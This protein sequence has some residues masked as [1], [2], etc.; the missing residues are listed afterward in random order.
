MRSRFV[1]ALATCSL[2]VLLVA[3]GNKGGTPA[4][5]AA[6]TKAPAAAPTKAPAASQP[7]QAVAAPTAA[8]TIAAQSPSANSDG[9]LAAGF[10]LAVP[11]PDADHADALGLAPSI[12]LNATEDPMVAYL[13]KNL[14]GDGYTLY[15]AQWD[16]SS[17]SWTKPVSIDTVNDTFHFSPQLKLA[18]DASNNLLGV[19][20]QQSDGIDRLALSTDNGATWKTEE[21]TPTNGGHSNNPSLAMAN[22][23]IYVAFTVDSPLTVFSRAGTSGAFTESAAPALPGTTDARDVA[24]GLAV[25]S[26][27]RPGVAYFLAPNDGSTITV[28]FWRPGEAKAY[29]VTDSNNTQNDGPNISLAFDGTK[30][31]IAVNLLRSTDDFNNG[32]MYVIT[33]DDGQTWAA[34]IHIQKD[35]GASMDGILSIAANPQSGVAIIAPTTGGSG[36]DKCGQPKLIQSVD[37]KTW[38]TCSPDA[39][40][41]LQLGA[42]Y[43]SAIFDSHGALYLAFMNSSA[44]AKVAPG[45]YVWRAK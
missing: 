18:R 23:N 38:V 42:E 14:N 5:A 15:F 26:A 32:S 28:A 40:Q 43:G 17:K 36:G 22:G 35:G 1:F 39:D 8:P 34:P 12:A 25:D 7:T 2:V 11:A 29:L 21:V 16:R 45:L 13:A 20:Y 41:S 19:A 27:G 24:P 33:S 30:P 9:S 37:L 10:N 3:C 44:F 4:P 6:P 31:R